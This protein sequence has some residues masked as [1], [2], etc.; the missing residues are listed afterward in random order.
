MTRKRVLEPDGC[1]FG[2]PVLPPEWQ[3]RRNDA[4]QQ[5]MERTR[6]LRAARLAAQGSAQR[7]PAKFK[8]KKNADVI[9]RRS[10]APRT[11]G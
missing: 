11:A 1:L 10:T 3:A 6:A 4:H 9:G 5:E 2:L 7:G 8:P